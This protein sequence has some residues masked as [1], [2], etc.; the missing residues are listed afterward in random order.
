MKG[1]IKF[2]SDKKGYGFVST[3]DHGDIYVHKSGVQDFGYFG[4][5]K[6]DLVSFEMKETPKGNQAINLKPIKE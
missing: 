1:N 3:E 6:G 2:Y 4:L 5:Q